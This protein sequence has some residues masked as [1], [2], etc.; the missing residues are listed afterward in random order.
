MESKEDRLKKLEAG[1]E[2]LAA[3]RKRKATKK[4][5]DIQKNV[6][7]TDLDAGDMQNHEN[8]IGFDPPS[9]TDMKDVWSDLAA[10]RK[11]K[12]TKKK[13][14]IQKN[15]DA[16]DLDAG[17]MQNHENGIGFDPS[18]LTDMKDVWSD[19]DQL[20]CTSE[21]EWS[22]EEMPSKS[23]VFLE[24]K[25]AQAKHR[26]AELE[27]A[28][29]GK[30]LALDAAIKN[31]ETSKL[32]GTFNAEA[33]NIESSSVDEN[34]ELTEFESALA[35]RD[36]LLSQL[37]ATLFESLGNT[38]L[39]A[40]VQAQVDALA[41]HVYQLQTQLH[42]ADKTLE[43]QLALH[44]S[45]AKAV[46]D[47]K[48]Q[49]LQLQEIITNKD[50]EL[51]LLTQQRNQAMLPEPSQNIGDGGSQPEI[52]DQIVAEVASNLSYAPEPPASKEQ[53]W[54]LREE[55]WVAR[56]KEWM[57]QEQRWAL[58]DEERASREQLLQASIESQA[59][60]IR[61]LSTSLEAMKAEEQKLQATCAQLEAQLEDAHT[62]AAD[63]LSRLELELQE[64]RE[65]HESD[66]NQI[67]SL[68]QVRQELEE[69]VDSQNASLSQKE[70]LQ[71]E[72]DALSSKYT[73]CLSLLRDSELAKCD[74]EQ[75]L[76]LVNLSTS[77]VDSN[78][79]L[80]RVKLNHQD[81]SEKQ[82]ESLKNYVELENK[83]SVDIDALNNKINE[84]QSV[85]QKSEAAL[86]DA[87]NA[88]EAERGSVAELQKALQEKN[89]QLGEQDL[90]LLQLEEA[91]KSLESEN[92]KIQQVLDSKEKIATSQAVEYKTAQD[93]LQQLE[94]ERCSYADQIAALQG[95]LIS[96]EHVHG[97]EQSEL[98]YHRD[99]MEEHMENMQTEIESLQAKLKEVEFKLTAEQ[100]SK[101]ELLEKIHKLENEL[102]T[103][104]GEEYS[105]LQSIQS[106]SNKLEPLQEQLQTSESGSETSESELST[107]AKRNLSEISR[108]ECDMLV[109]KIDSL[110]RGMDQCKSQLENSEAMVNDLTEKL[111]HSEE[112]LSSTK[113]ELNN[114]QQINMTSAKETEIQLEKLQARASEAEQLQTRVAALEDMEQQLLERD[115]CQEELQK[116]LEDTVSHWQKLQRIVQEKE[117]DLQ[118]SEEMLEEQ[119]RICATLRKTFN[120]ER[121]EFESEINGL[122]DTLQHE[123]DERTKVDCEVW[124]LRGK[125]QILE[126][127]I[128]VLTDTKCSNMAVLSG[129]VAK[130][131]TELTQAKAR[132][133]IREAEILA[134][135]QG[136]EER[137]EN[138]TIDITEKDTEIG[139]LKRDAQVKEKEIS[140]LKTELS[141]VRDENME[142]KAAL[143]Q[144]ENAVTTLKAQLEGKDLEIKDLTSSDQSEKEKMQVLEIELDGL[145]KAF[146]EISSSVNQNI[147]GPED[148]LAEFKKKEEDFVQLQS[149][150]R[151]LEADLENERCSNKQAV[152]A[153]ETEFE[154]TREELESTLAERSTL[155]K[156]LAVM[157]LQA[158]DVG[159]SHEQLQAAHSEVLL[160]LDDRDQSLQS[161]A[162]E[163]E[164][165]GA[166]LAQIK[167][168]LCQVE[169]DHN[170]L[171]GTH[172]DLQAKHKEMETTLQGAE[173]RKCELETELAQVRDELSM[174][175]TTR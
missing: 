80:D 106:L 102:E 40:T 28:M 124:D 87:R 69:K 10:F 164:S 64:L 55:E 131:Q 161:V 98:Q 66:Q 90:K 121:E 166:E 34:P 68:S 74:L 1:K 5:R 155:Q 54:A 37:S 172:S 50:Q 158:S 58:R 92:R 104:T 160:K 65:A 81:E 6:D 8:G 25:L 127:E 149:V 53:V 109:S 38:E 16:T 162:Q 77:A 151:Q 118:K 24:A 71:E 27:E 96:A 43:E 48:F 56:E 86:Q 89:E 62:M 142:Q 4:K 95:E 7:A 63:K 138:L 47:A 105:L 119:Q 144:V 125:V 123:K 130:L 70:A 135:Q 31:S 61:N 59:A 132:S 44:N 30:Q 137:V 97:V 41:E 120:E 2:K 45:S 114:V 26:I 100:D 112:T 88:T 157:K 78:T 126:G 84:L 147:S 110:T 128:E 113:M 46:H 9:L 72:Y 93:A 133:E 122:K 49:M 117:V 29:E 156:E 42:Q 167:E 153:V 82:I 15:V 175:K 174:L 13:R 60:Q 36:A 152:E 169:A 57:S 107:E 52:E 134:V 32:Q 165:I 51:A 3:F 21:D 83:Y 17:D 39:N 115:K 33:S 163:K 22:T 154:K 171:L 12:A 141:G 170:L 35:Q 91:C 140:D 108:K 11:R 20:S 18:S 101:V 148:L 99:K 67:Q 136:I 75:K 145:R 150:V 94:K 19:S 129:T 73:E 143:V 139:S 85:V 173:K 14:D 23:T 146:A 79:E 168:R 159:N 116:Q 111:K 103:A 76:Q